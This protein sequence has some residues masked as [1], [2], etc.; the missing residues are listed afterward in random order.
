M[1][2]IGLQSLKIISFKNALNKDFKITGLGE[3]K[4]ILG[5][6]VI[7][8][9][10]N[11]L[12]Y[13]NQLAY[14]HQI[15]IR[16]GIQDANIISTLLLVKYNLIL[17]QYSKTNKKKQAYKDYTRSIH[18]LSLVGLL[19][20]TTQTW[21]NIQFSVRLIAQFSRN[22][23]LKAAKRILCYLKNI[24][25]LNLIL[26]RYRKKIFDLVGWTNSN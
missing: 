3:L 14:I 15:L 13:L 10:K 20:F 11:W 6:I 24:V 26:E 21:P 22:P 1:A 8:D 17:S 23:R 4:Y 25:D 12:I 16:F 2:I 5:I 7:W 19:L 18:Y 9:H